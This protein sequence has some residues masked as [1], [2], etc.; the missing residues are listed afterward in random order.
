M[1]GQRRPGARAVAGDDVER[2]RRESGLERQLGQAQRGE[3]RVLGGLQHDAAAGGKRRADLPDRHQQREIPRD[4]RARPRRPAR[5][6]C[7]RRTRSC[8]SRR[9]RD[10]RPSCLRSWSPSPR[11]SAG[12]PPP[13]GRRRAARS[14]AACRCRAFRSRRTRR[15]L[16][17]SRSASL[18]S[19]RSRSTG[20]AA[21]HSRDSNAAR[22]A[23]TA[24]ST[25]AAVGGGNRGDHF[26]GRGVANVEPRAG[27]GVAP[28]A[29]DQHL[30][31]GGEEP[32]SRLARGGGACRGIH[33]ERLLAPSRFGREARPGADRLNG[34]PG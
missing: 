20:R 31:R 25:S 24:R 28:L 21:P 26:A 5:A 27:D 30:A 33:G 7:R 15:A 29:A 3:R 4:D 6:A 34:L 9:H 18:S 32:G 8:G 17:S 11:S 2:A 16:A 14:P 23:R 1:R 19:Q 10:A 22:A 13:T 12:S